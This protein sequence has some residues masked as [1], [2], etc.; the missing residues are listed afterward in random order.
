VEHKK[1]TD[2]GM[3]NTGNRSNAGSR[4]SGHNAGGSSHGGASNKASDRDRTKSGHGRS[5]DSTSTGK[6]SAREPPPCLST[7]QCAGEKHYLSY[8]PHAGR[9]EAIVL[10]LEHKK[11]RDADKKKVNF[12]ILGNNRATTE[13]IDDQTAYL[14]PEHLGGKVTV[15]ADTGFDYFAIPRSAVED[16]QRRGVAGAHNAVYGYQGRKEQTEVQCDGDSH[17]SGDNIDAVGA[18]VHEWHTIDHCRRRDILTIH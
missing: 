17:V 15:L 7:R 16:S 2:S 11:K 5:S 4:S 8:C 13:N 10:L 1:T 14:T 12:K 9:D 18:S 6:Q 3:K